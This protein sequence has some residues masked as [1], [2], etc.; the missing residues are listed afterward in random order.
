LIDRDELIASLPR[1]RRYA[2]LLAGDRSRADDL[3][4]DAITRAIERESSFHAGQNLRAWLFA[5]MHNIFVDSMRNREAIDWAADPDALPESAAPAASDPL[6]LR[7]IHAALDKL[8]LEQR[9]VLILVGIEGLRYREAAD[10]LG[11]P[12]GTV[13]SR[14]ARGREKMQELLGEAAL[15]GAGGRA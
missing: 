15:A 10:A 14:L 7:E 2:R 11:L 3:V 6:Q 8:P 12:L 13:M 9:A 5:L 1:L 4:Q